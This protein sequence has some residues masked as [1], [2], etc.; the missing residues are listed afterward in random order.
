MTPPLPNDTPAIWS[1]GV[2]APPLLS[3]AS[4]TELGERRSCDTDGQ[5]A[6][7]RRVYARSNITT[8]G[9]VLQTSNDPD[10]LNAL[11]SFYPLPTS[12]TD[13]GPTTATRMQR[14]AI[15]APALASTAAMDALTTAGVAPARVTHLVSVSCTGFCAPGLDV[16]LIRRLALRPTVVRTHVGFMGCH[17]ALNALTAA[18]SIARADP[19][20][21]VL[22]CCVELCTLHFAYGWSPD[23]VIA[24]SLFADGAAAAIVAQRPP[25][26]TGRP[27]WH[28]DAAASLLVPDSMDAMTWR[29]GDHGYEMT[30]AAQVPEMIGRH[31]RAWCTEW[32][33]SNGAR[34]ADVAHW[35]V[36]PGGPRILTAVEATLDLPPAALRPSRDVLAG[37]GN[38]SSATVLFILRQMAIEHARGPC[39]AMGFGPGLTMEGMLLHRD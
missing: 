39:V 2:A 28:L 9:S 14:Y 4:V 35:A 25:A 29:I 27:L 12:S 18:R 26:P 20:A 10:D 16:E 37:L 38:M 8:R 19:D 1:I 24:N 11:Q 31:L 21:V 7:L 34:L 22:I 17:A 30:L 36:H 33:G 15:E 23:R 5:R 32:L 3:Q 6:F 13:R